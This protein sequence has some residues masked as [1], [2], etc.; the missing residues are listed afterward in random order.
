MVRIAIVED[1]PEDVLTLE[2]HLERFFAETNEAYRSI[3]Y[4]D[5]ESFLKGFGGD[6]DLVLMDI[7]LPGMSGMDCARSLRQIDGGVTLIFITN[8]ARYAVHGYEV[9]ALDFIVKPVS[10]S[11]FSMKMRRAMGSIRRNQESCIHLDIKGGFVRLDVSQI[12]YLDV[13][14]HYITYHTELGSFLVRESLKAAEKKLEPFH[15]IRANASCLV[16]PRHVRLLVDGCIHMADGDI[17]L[18]R[19]CRASFMKSL[20]DYMGGNV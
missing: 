19:S 10:Y 5:P 3:L 9:G 7:G 6:T 1:D 18:S 16:N 4:R 2:Y 14:K 15:F 13:Q 12:I 17:Y 11:A 20:A 8:L